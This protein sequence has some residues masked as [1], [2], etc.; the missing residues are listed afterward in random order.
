MDIIKDDQF[1]YTKAWSLASRPVT[2]QQLLRVFNKELAPKNVAYTEYT[3]LE[4]MLKDDTVA[5]RTIEGI[6][7][8][9]NKTAGVMSFAKKT[10]PKKWNEVIKNDFSFLDISDP[11]FSAALDT[12]VNSDSDVCLVG[13]AGTGKCLAGSEKIN[14]RLDEATF[15]KFQEFLEL[16]N[17]Q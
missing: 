1:K 13:Q 8:Y 15:E 12:L 14:I 6:T 11:D 2:I 3:L 17:S 5:S 7:Y 10:L 9:V 16:Q 4:S